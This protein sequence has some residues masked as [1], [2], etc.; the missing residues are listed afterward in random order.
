[1]GLLPLGAHRRHDAVGPLGVGA[2]QPAAALRRVDG[3]ALGRKQRQ[4]P[5]API[6]GDVVAALHLVEERDGPAPLAGADAVL[7]QRA[8][9]RSVRPFLGRRR[10]CAPRPPIG[11]RRAAARASSASSASFQAPTPA[12]RPPPSPPAAPSRRRRRPPR[13]RRGRSAASLVLPRGGSRRAR[14][15]LRPRRPPP[16]Q[17]PGPPSARALRTRPRRPR[18]RRPLQRR[19]RLRRERVFVVS[20]VGVG[21]MRSS[22]ENAASSPA[23]AARDRLNPPA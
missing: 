18:R 21:G 14:R 23:S 4:V 8:V 11:R 20:R 6:N 9:E 16:G 15:L 22:S 1:M 12:R 3:E 17:A 5:V 10:A 7:Q 2:A 19:R 13:G